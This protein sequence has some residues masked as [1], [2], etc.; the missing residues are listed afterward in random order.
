[1]I[2]KHNDFLSVLFT[3]CKLR[4][5]RIGTV[6]VCQRPLL[7]VLSEYKQNEIRTQAMT[8]TGFWCFVVT[9]SSYLYAKMAYN[10]CTGKLSFKPLLQL[11]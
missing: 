4:P 7:L 11:K 1:M 5:A 10:K 9:N 6:N 2:K 3:G 8:L